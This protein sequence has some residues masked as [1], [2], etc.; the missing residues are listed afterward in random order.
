MKCRVCWAETGGRRYEARDLLLRLP[1][2]FP[3]IECTSCGSLQIERIP[4]DLGRHYP[5]TYYSF[6]SAP[7]HRFRNPLRAQGQRFRCRAA[8]G[9][10]GIVSNWLLRHYP[11]RPLES[12]RRLRPNSST[13][14]LDVGCGNG[15]LIRQLFD[16]GFRQV[17]GV[18]PYLANAVAERDGFRILKAPL[19]A[20]EGKWDVVMF[21]HS[22]EHVPDPYETLQQAADR[23]AETGT[24]VVRIPTVSSYAWR[25][26]G[27]NWYALDAPRHLVLF[28]RD[29]LALLAER[30][31]LYIETV[32]D[33][34]AASQF[35][36]S[37]L[38]ARGIP[39]PSSRPHSFAPRSAFSAKQIR[40]FE[41]QARELNQRGEGDQAVFYL[42]KR[43]L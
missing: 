30:A 36:C 41:A 3:Y 43:V 26:Y 2:T 42:K 4:A 38:C 20:V 6:S 27:T 18:D 8:L 40:S 21:H 32:V 1:E 9:Q 25:H 33:D 19:T 7:A 35:W 12:L 10:G 17:L 29:G 37:E 5:P 22:F 34:S 23:L 13:R 16:A 11:N 24:C 28:S 31:G 14:F 15:R 39:Y